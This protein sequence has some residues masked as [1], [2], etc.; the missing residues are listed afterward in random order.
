MTHVIRSLAKAHLSRDPNSLWYYICT[1]KN[2]KK[3]TCTFP[4]INNCITWIE[5]GIHSMASL[6]GTR[7]VIG[8][9]IILSSKINYTTPLIG[10]L[11]DMK[12]DTCYQQSYQNLNK[13]DSFKLYLL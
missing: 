9:V 4:A 7:Q 3:K 2:I 11:C 8:V 5:P 10:N 1:Q 13:L 6:T 12:F